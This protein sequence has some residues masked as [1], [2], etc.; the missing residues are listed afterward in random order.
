MLQFRL[1]GVSALAG[2]MSRDGPPARASIAT[3]YLATRYFL[4]GSQP[5]SGPLILPK[6]I[7]DPGAQPF[8][9]GLSGLRHLDAPGAG[10]AH[11]SV[12]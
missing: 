1:H 7:P 9:N 4:L 5:S 6:G 11:G 10:P 2:S 3:R 12:L 8:S